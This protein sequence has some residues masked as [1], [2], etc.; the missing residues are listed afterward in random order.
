MFLINYQRKT[1]PILIAKQIDIVYQKIE[2]DKF[3]A[4][5]H[6]TMLFSKRVSQ[7]YHRVI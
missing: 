3:R 1:I 7:N 6:K 5:F 4:E 2:V